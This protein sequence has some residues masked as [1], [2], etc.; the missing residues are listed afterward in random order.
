M[1]ELGAVAR[2]AN[3]DVALARAL[4]ELGWTTTKLAA[5][6]DVEDEVVDG[7]LLAVE[8]KME[9][10]F[11]ANE[12][13][14]LMEASEAAAQSLWASS[15]GCDDS[16]LAMQ[17]R[18][19]HTRLKLDAIRS[20]RIE[21][22]N[23]SIQ[24]VGEAPRSTWPTKVDKRLAM[25]GDDEKLREGV[26]KSERDRWLER[27]RR[28]LREGA[29]VFDVSW[30]DD[31][32]ILARRMG[33][34]R[35][36]NTLRK[37]V[38]VWERY[39]SWLKPV[40]GVGWPVVPAHFAGYL[41]ARASEPC[42]RTIP[43]SVF[44]TLVFMEH[45]AEVP[46]DRQVGQS[47]AVRNALEE[48]TMQLEA[49]GDNRRRQARLIPVS[50]I[51]AM[52]RAVMNTDLETYIRGFAWY[53]LAKVWTCMRFHD[54]TG[55]DF[56]SARMD[57]SCWSADLRRTKTSG[58]GKKV[59]VL[60][61]FIT[62]EAF[63]EERRWLETGWFLWE[64]MAEETFTSQRD[65]FLPAPQVG[66]MRH[67]RRMASYAAAS[68]STQALFAALTWRDTGVEEKML[69]DGVGSLWTEHSER[70]TMRTW[71]GAAG[72]PESICK[73]MGRWTPTVDQ[74]YDR[75]VK[76]QVMTAQE[77]TATYIRRNLGRTDPFDE[78]A[79]LTEVCDRLNELG[80]GLPEVRRQLIRLES[81]ADLP[82]SCVG[83]PDGWVARTQAG[84]RPKEWRALVARNSHR[85]KKGRSQIQ[86]CAWETTW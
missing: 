36:A 74:A 68:A 65:F 73:R 4:S 35:R 63:V 86:R 26:E 43:L 40:F 13:R 42:G 33:K 53:K 62:K 3:L 85:R 80:T 34:G 41:E 22:I 79:V 61:V 72:V 24:R 51:I 9:E 84:R 81:K 11:D 21:A 58:P 6:S 50:L 83:R 49:G 17:S 30:D 52:E 67:Q 7:V 56:G 29:P 44:K 31:V 20:E 82:R 32:G 12:L 60:K 70:V 1:E 64:Q 66:L 69:V 37:H 76:A 18:L 48:V 39:I 2:I 59:A 47:L 25:V 23:R 5:I 71:A 55:L 57:S 54:T 78:N 75:S 14:R 77:H 45:A 15:S 8:E 19:S 27:L 16:D 46:R 38:K 10:K 28:L